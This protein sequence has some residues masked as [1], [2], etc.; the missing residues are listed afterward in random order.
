MAVAR[1]IELPTVGELLWLHEAL[2]ERLGWEE[3]VRELAALELALVL[4]YREAETSPR[5]SR[6]MQVARCGAVLVRGLL[7]YR[8]FRQ[9]NAATAWM[10]LVRFLEAN[11]FE[12]AASENASS[13]MLSALIRGHKD[14]E[15]FRSWL[16]RRLRSRPARAF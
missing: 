13:R 12:L 14:I 15:A 7:E 3:E 6:A 5:Q 16:L 9:G 2:S 1:P 4:L 11:G 8:P 10:A